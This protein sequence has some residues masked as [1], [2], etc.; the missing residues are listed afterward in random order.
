MH[1]TVQ[2]P[3]TLHLLFA[4][5]TEAIQALG[6]SDVAED[7]FHHRHAVT[8]DLFASRAVHAVLHPVRVV[9]QAFV[10]D[11]ERYLSTGTFTVI[12]RGRVLHALVFLR[13]MPALEKAAFEV[14]PDFAVLGFAGALVTD[15]VACRTDTGQIHRIELEFAGWD[16]GFPA[17]FG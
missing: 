11:G 15:G 13:A 8:V 14:H 6:R 9:R 7:R 4:P 17:G 2:L 12:G 10:F 3:L 1:Q 16:D 5:Q